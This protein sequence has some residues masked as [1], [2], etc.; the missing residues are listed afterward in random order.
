[1]TFIDHAGESRLVHIPATNF[2]NLTNDE[3][4]DLANPLFPMPS[5][6]ETRTALETPVHVTIRKYLDQTTDQELRA[7]I[8]PGI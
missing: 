1:M 3:I 6:I 2:G 4:Q 5:D 8:T 7:A